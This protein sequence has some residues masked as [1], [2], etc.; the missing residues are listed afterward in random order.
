[1]KRHYP[2]RG[3]NKPTA[4]PQPTIMVCH[5]CREPFFHKDGCLFYESRKREARTVKRNEKT[6]KVF[7][8]RRDF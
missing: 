3:V 2:R 1:M 5:H 8:T 6:F 4:P 7:G